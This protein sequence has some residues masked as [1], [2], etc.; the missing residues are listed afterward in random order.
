M[1]PLSELR[2]FFHP[3]TALKTRLGG[4]ALSQAAARAEA[5]RCDLQHWFPTLGLSQHRVSFAAL[6]R[7]VGER[8]FVTGCFGKQASA[9]CL[10]LLT[11]RGSV[12]AAVC[13]VLFML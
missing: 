9:V 10:V 12:R 7:S 13:N 5:P 3:S 6:S 4:A 11:A 1:S 8:R 2:L